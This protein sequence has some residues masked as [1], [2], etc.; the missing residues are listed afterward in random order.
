HFLHDRRV[1]WLFC[2]KVLRV[3]E[4]KDELHVFLL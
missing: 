2:G 1:C 3:I 4:L